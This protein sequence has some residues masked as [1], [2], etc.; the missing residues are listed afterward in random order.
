[1]LCLVT[2][3]LYNT[4]QPVHIAYF[5]LRLDFT[6]SS[7]IDIHFNRV[8]FADNVTHAPQS[9]FNGNAACPHIWAESL[10][11][12]SHL[13]TSLSYKSRFLQASISCKCQILTSQVNQTNRRLIGHWLIAGSAEPQVELELAWC[14]LQA[15]SLSLIQCY[16][17]RK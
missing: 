15:A 13:L 11:Y 16:F 14:S 17:F 1:M 6:A 7:H 2:F 10:A 8:Y 3:L 4:S 12:K 5:T 9:G